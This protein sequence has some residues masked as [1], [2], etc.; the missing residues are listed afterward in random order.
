MSKLD[1]ILDNQIQR[2]AVDLQYYRRGDIAQARS[3]GVSALLG[4]PVYSYLQ[5]SGEAGILRID[6][7]L[8]VVG[9]EKNI[10]KTAIAGRKGTVKELINEGDYAIQVNGKLVSEKGSRPETETA[11]LIAL[12]KEGSSLQVESPFLEEFGISTI[13]IDN[14]TVPQRAGRINEQEFSFSAY[15]DE[16]IELTLK[17]NV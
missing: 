8:M 14:A 2:S 9:V 1:I 13:A 16:A 6:N 4:T 12:L 10:T 15:S 17:E 3:Y 7:V 5:L 11:L